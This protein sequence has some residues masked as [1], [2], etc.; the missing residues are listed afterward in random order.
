M[1]R[2]ELDRYLI[3][4]NGIYFYRRRVPRLVAALDERQPTVRAS[5]RTRDLAKARAL[6]DG[7]E[8]ADDELWGAL[9]GSDSAEAA[10]RRYEAAVRRVAALGFTY[11]TTME[12]L[13]GETGA[14]ILDR[15]RVLLEHRPNSPETN[16]VLGVVE[17]PGVRLSEA[18]AL[19]V[20][21]IAA[22]EL[23]N[24][25]GEQ[26]RSWLKVKKRAL[27][28]FTSLV[29]DKPIG[30]VTREDALRLYDLWAERIAPPPDEDGKRR[31]PTH[32][33][34]SGNRDIGN[35][36]VLY[37]K[38]HE[39]IGVRNI[40]NP[41]DKLA[42]SDRHQRAR[43]RPPFPTA[44]IA[45]RILAPDA[46]RALNDQAR[47]IVLAM[48]DTGARPSELANLPPERIVLAAPV[49]YIDI[50]TRPDDDD[51]EELGPCE[52][53][54]VSSYRQIPLVGLALAVFRKHP[55]G[56]PRY[57]DRADALSAVLNKHFRVHKLFPTPR[58][59]IY[60]LRH[61]F[62]DRMKVAGVDAELRAILFGHTAARP[63]YGQGGSLE[64]QRDQL[65]KIVL[66]FDRAI[67]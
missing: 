31:R 45:E 48:V 16:A 15:L 4:R 67:V 33:A 1:E 37:R 66:P 54:T 53:K 20:E 22:P 63:E 55:R 61:S 23:V 25:S 13:Q 57:R 3:T 27:K 36:R 41:F 26:R 28:N 21:K 32:T 62:E 6:R 17:R 50:Q 11:R 65:L 18:F 34:S 52:V 39:H 51:E 12:I 58:H 14:Q 2:T 24:K 35:M 40:D 9:L 44:W 10:R 30:E 47:G 56:F 42:F 59:K 7:Y 46:L 38:Y 49:P 64:W 8:R 19:Y 5:L 43:R 29:G 60:S